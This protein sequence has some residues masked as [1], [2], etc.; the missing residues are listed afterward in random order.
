MKWRTLILCVV[1]IILLFAIGEKVQAGPRYINGDAAHIGTVESMLSSLPH[2][3]YRVMN[4]QPDYFIRFTNWSGYCY[5]TPW[6][7]NTYGIDV[8]KRLWGK[9]FSDQVGHEW[10]HSI[11]NLKGIREE[12]YK[13]TDAMGIPRLAQNGG[14]DADNT[15]AEDCSSALYGPYWCGESHRVFDRKQMQDWLIEMGVL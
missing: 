8:N 7:P 3:T 9:A 4:E 14:K 1:I 5:P 12:W 15:F 13:V 10:C 11:L 6:R 2:I